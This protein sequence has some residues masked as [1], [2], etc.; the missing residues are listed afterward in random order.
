MDDA[1]W[2]G[3]FWNDLIYPEYRYNE[4]DCPGRLAEWV[5]QEK[6]QGRF[7]DY[8]VCICV[9]SLTESKEFHAEE[10]HMISFCQAGICNHLAAE[11]RL[12]LGFAHYNHLY[13]CG[14]LA[15]KSEEAKTSFLQSLEQMVENIN[16]QEVVKITAGL[17]FLRKPSMYFFKRAAQ[18]AVVAQRSKV[19][20]G[21]GRLYVL[22]D[23]TGPLEDLTIPLSLSVQVWKH[24][25]KGGSG[26]DEPECLKDVVKFLFQ[27]RYIPLGQMRPLIQMMIVL[28]AWAA[29]V[30]GVPPSVSMPKVLE[31]LNATNNIFDYTSYKRLISLALHEF[32]LTV[33]N[34]SENRR[35][36]NPV[37]AKAEKY[38]ANHLTDS[39]SLSTIAEA[40]QVNRYYLSKQFAK[41]K[42]ITLTAYITQQRLYLAKSLLLDPSLSIADIAHA[43][44]FGTIQ[45]FNRVFKASEGCTPSTYR[46]VR[47]HP[48][49]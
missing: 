10:R 35:Q 1:L 3:A 40:L 31:F 30:A 25:L 44:G 38:I 4:T 27:T 9:D 36:E 2:V 41:A 17:S 47:L 15:D 32:S 37:V 26:A 16:A 6:L 21:G 33:R 29:G 13:F 11:Q 42:G 39:L 24:I 28:M 46:A 43:S 8:V 34:L 20:D 12:L 7:P 23:A 5:I 14:I 18:C 22:A 19:R 48:A 45:H 49:I